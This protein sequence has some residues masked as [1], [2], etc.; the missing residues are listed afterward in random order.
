[1]TIRAKT[2]VFEGKKKINKKNVYKGTQTKLTVVNRE[3]RQILLDVVVMRCSWW[4]IFF[5]INYLCHAAVKQPFCVRVCVCT[6]TCMY[7]VYVRVCA[8]ACVCGGVYQVFVYLCVC[9]MCAP[10]RRS[11]THTQRSNQVGG[12]PRV[13]SCPPTVIVCIYGQQVRGG[14]TPPARPPTSWVHRSI[15]C[16]RS[17]YRYVGYKFSTQIML[18]IYIYINY[19]TYIYVYKYISAFC[20]HCLITC[21]SHS[22]IE[23]IYPPY[24]HQH[25]CSINSHIT[26]PSTSIIHNSP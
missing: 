19:N 26:T 8:C 20:P 25:P 6:C 10:P 7:A 11:C 5:L 1:M 15:L 24:L 14:T 12:T 18:Y 9:I 2:T 3:F 21:F 23:K 4:R 17:T 16:P 13:S 22:I